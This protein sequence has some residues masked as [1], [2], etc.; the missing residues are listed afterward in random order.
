MRSRSVCSDQMGSS[1]FGVNLARATTVNAVLA[2]K[3]GGGSMMIWGCRS[4]NGV[5]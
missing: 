3:H 1:M 2:V 4:V 5:L